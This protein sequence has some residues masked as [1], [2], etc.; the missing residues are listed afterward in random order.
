MPEFSEDISAIEYFFFVHYT[1][2]FTEIWLV[3]RWILPACFAED[4]RSLT[5]G[6][7]YFWNHDADEVHVANYRFYIKILVTD[8]HEISGDW[9]LATVLYISGWRPLFFD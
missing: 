5:Y 9:I 6:M 3:I 7:V 1:P 4:I 2:N 8:L